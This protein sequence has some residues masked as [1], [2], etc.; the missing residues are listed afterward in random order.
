MSTEQPGL[1]GE[2]DKPQIEQYVAEPEN[3]PYLPFLPGIA[4]GEAFPEVGNIMELEAVARRCSRCRLR[5]TC[6]QVVFA[7]GPHDA[8]IMLIGEGPGQE[9]DIQGKPFVGRAGQLLDKIL[10]AA[11][12]QR[13]EVY[14]S[15]VVKCR[16]PGNRLPNPDEVKECQKY[17]E[18]QIRIIKPAIIVCLGSM[19][20]Q[21]V[22]E[23]K[24]RITRIRGS[25][26]L[27]QG[28]KIM[29]TYHP[30]ALLR[31]PGYKRPTWEDFKLIRDE[32]KKIKK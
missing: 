22:I 2:W 28:I 27:R 8:R 29:P 16:P 30:A 21:T 4:P 18:A 10:Q 23:S 3:I 5:G 15:N 14:I 19:A 20:S 6:Q 1:F 13:D 11:E 24:A 25:W 9:E 17:L 12:L 7:D 32:Y 26:L 31:N